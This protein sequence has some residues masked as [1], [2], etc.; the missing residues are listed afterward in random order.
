MEN[1]REE[2]ALAVSLAQE[3]G[4]AVMAH[5]ETALQVE[6]KADNSPV[7]LAD[8]G[9]EE[10]LRKRMEKLTP[11]YGII[12]EEF[13]AQPGSTGREWVI[14]PID[15]TKAFI[16]GVPLFGTLLALLENGRPVVGVVVL[17]A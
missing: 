11:D 13:G 9:A 5:F 15:G 14:D 17:P 4:R 1:Y 10:L 3:A 6:T 2:L 12:G 8:R 7:T 16:H